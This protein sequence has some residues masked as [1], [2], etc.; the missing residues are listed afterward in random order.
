MSL[1]IHLFWGV[2]TG[3]GGHPI[4][5]VDRDAAAGRR[6]K[7]KSICALNQV[8][9]P[10]RRTFRCHCRAEIKVIRAALARNG[11]LQLDK[12]IRPPFSV[13][14][15]TADRKNLTNLCNG[16]HAGSL[17]IADRSSEPT[18]SAV[19]AT[20]ASIA[21]YKEVEMQSVMR[22]TTLVPLRRMQLQTTPTANLTSLAILH[23]RST[24]VPPL[25]SS[26]PSTLPTRFVPRTLFA[27]SSSS[28]S[29]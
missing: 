21:S 28:F 18:G 10:M 11:K 22:L 16:P 2:S 19:N 29:L 24:L 1:V 7:K 17:H 5:R 25:A 4:E 3:L 13:G 27:S 8:D 15:C 14:R 6:R 9:W 26:P 12:L 20:A 23:F